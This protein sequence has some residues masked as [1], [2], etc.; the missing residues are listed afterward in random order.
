VNGWRRAGSIFQREIIERVSKFSL[1]L[2]E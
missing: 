1:G 2:D